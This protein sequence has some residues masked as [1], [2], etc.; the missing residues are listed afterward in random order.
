MSQKL[1]RQPKAQPSKG[2]IIVL[3]VAGFIAFCT[4]VIGGII[5]FVL[6]PAY[7]ALMDFVDA[8]GDSDYS[9]AFDDYGDDEDDEDDDDEEE[10]D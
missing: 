7:G 10:D 2:P 5:A 1:H 4:V 6:R 9:F 3:G 8:L